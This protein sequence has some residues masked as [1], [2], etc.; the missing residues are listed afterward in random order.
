MSGNYL[1]CIHWQVLHSWCVSGEQAWPAYRTSGWWRNGTHLA[2]FFWHIHDTGTK[3]NRQTELGT[4]CL[5]FTTMT[6]PAYSF[7]FT[8]F[9]TSPHSY[10]IAH[11]YIIIHSC[12]TISR[13]REKNDDTVQD[14]PPWMCIQFCVLLLQVQSQKMQYSTLPNDVSNGHYIWPKKTVPLLKSFFYICHQY[15]CILSK[16]SKYPSAHG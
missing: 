1:T 5:L 16:C 4:T 10:I 15:S 3:R 7:I 12:S 2:F 13:N 9:A 6:M 11:S 14:E 8:T